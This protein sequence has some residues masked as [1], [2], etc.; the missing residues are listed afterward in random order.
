M[1][2]ENRPEGR[3]LLSGG[4]VDGVKSL[5]LNLRSGGVGPREVLV[6]GRGQVLQSNISKITGLVKEFHDSEK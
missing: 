3:S 2:Q 6:C 5:F 1:P 4:S